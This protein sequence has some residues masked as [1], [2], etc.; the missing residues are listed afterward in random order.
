V[1]SGL[2]RSPSGSAAIRSDV[3]RP[4]R[5][6]V[7]QWS[8][9]RDGW[10][11]LLA[12]ACL[13]LSGCLGRPHT[14]EAH[15][16]TVLVA[17]HRNG[18]SSMRIVGT[19]RVINDCLGLDLATNRWIPVFPEGSEVAEDGLSVT[20]SNGSELSVGDKI[21]AGGD[22][23]DPDDPMENAPAVPERCGEISAALLDEPQILETGK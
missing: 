16:V 11:I 12:G 13:L 4:G 19:L 8:V 1:T 23:Y 22:F 17:G 20:L 5:L 21:E 7:V 9:R 2:D 18:A 14:V 6:S 15:G 10:L 3:R